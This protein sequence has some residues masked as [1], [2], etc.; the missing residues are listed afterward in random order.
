MEY[1]M[2]RLIRRH[3]DTPLPLRFSKCVQPLQFRGRWVLRIP[4]RALFTQTSTA[5]GLPLLATN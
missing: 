5:L 3:V 2:L 4:E 1:T